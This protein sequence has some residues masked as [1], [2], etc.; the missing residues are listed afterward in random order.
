MCVCLF[1][2]EG[3]QRELNTD[4]ANTGQMLKQDDMSQECKQ[5]D[6]SI[7]NVSL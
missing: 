5:A 4:I 2:S 1:M 6:P 3:V 7:R